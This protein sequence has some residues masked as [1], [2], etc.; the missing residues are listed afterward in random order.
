MSKP[1]NQNNM[2]NIPTHSSMVILSI[3]RYY[4][5]YMNIAISYIIIDILYAVVNDIT[6]SRYDKRKILRM[7][8]LW[9]QMYSIHFLSYCCYC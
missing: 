8:N 1:T 6:N 2:K 7:K 3:L 5:Q 9:I 4:G